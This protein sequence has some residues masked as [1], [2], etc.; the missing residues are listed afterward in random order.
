M[1]STETKI[2]SAKIEIIG[3]NP[4]VYLPDNVL[5]SIFIQANKDKGKIP[6]KIKI[7]GYEFPQTLIKYS[8]QWRLYLNTPMRKSAN[9]DVGDKA[10]FEIWF[11]PEERIVAA[12]PK[13]IKALKE[14]KEA[15]KKFDS[16]RPSLQLE[17]IRY[18]SF[19]KTEES[20]DRNV[21]KAVNFLLGKQ[22]FIGRDK[23]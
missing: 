18:L 16:L 5:K 14:N 6:V 15:K 21:M 10:K 17:I 2:F 20:L 7:D 11:D 3:V 22:R 12:H 23:P 1:D 4:F 19:L 8:G 13:F 9:K